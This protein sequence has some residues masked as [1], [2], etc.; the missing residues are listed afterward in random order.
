MFV[1]LK[2]NQKESYH[3]RGPPKRRHVHVTELWIFCFLQGI[4]HPAKKQD[5]LVFL[6]PEEVHHPKGA[7]AI[8]STHGQ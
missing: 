2:G 1:V 8:L 3:C 4:G 6:F 7:S 5:G